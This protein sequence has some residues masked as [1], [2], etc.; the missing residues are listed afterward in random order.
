MDLSITKEML[1]LQAVN[2]LCILEHNK[3]T[4]SDRYF[5]EK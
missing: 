2:F 1:Y 5:Y 4:L 3:L